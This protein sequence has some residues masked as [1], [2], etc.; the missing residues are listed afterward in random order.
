M[1]RT[2]SHPPC[3][4]RCL[5]KLCICKQSQS[6]NKKRKCKNDSNF[7]VLKKQRVLFESKTKLFEEK[8][9]SQEKILLEQK[10]TYHENL[11]IQ[12]NEKLKEKLRE[13]IVS[14]EKF[15]AL[16]IEYFLQSLKLVFCQQYIMNMP[17]FPQCQVNNNNG[18][19]ENSIEKTERP[20]NSN[21]KNPISRRCS[22]CNQY[23]HYAKTC[24]SPQR[25][26]S[27]EQ[28]LIPSPQLEPH[29]EENLVENKNLLI[30][31]LEQR[32]SA[33][34]GADT[35]SNLNGLNGQ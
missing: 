26:T 7:S 8:L 5:E 14:E 17:Q 20:S 28:T 19:K 13:K 1:N 21:H 18:F 33:K 6:I 31:R 29:A 24:H 15:K 27:K 16:E 12:M 2:R 4:Y 9:L 32:I 11:S 22:Y 30:Q 34:E 23:G 35:L 10:L 25:E 3:C